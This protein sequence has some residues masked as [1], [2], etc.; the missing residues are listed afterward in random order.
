MCREVNTPCARQP[1]LMRWSV[2]RLMKTVQLINLHLI[3]KQRTPTTSCNVCHIA[4][5]WRL[6]NSSCKSLSAR[7]RFRCWYSSN[8][9]ICLDWVFKSN[10]FGFFHLPVQ[11]WPNYDCNEYDSSHRNVCRHSVWSQEIRIIITPA[12]RSICCFSAQKLWSSFAMTNFASKK[13]H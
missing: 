3:W 11:I 7:F 5:N 9:L 8:S 1:P 13:N 2:N 4:Q 12:N 10:N 6:H